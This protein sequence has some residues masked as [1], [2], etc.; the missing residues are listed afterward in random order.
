MGYGG[1]TI[2]NAHF[3]VEWHL[4]GGQS[5][6]SPVQSR[7]SRYTVHTIFTGALS[8]GAKGVPNGGSVKKQCGPNTRPVA[9][10]NALVSYP[11]GCRLSDKTSFDHN[12]IVEASWTFSDYPGYWYFFVRSPV[13]HSTDKVTYRFGLADSLPGNA[14]LGGWNA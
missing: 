3:L 4:T 5:L 14:A 9:A 13:S 8:N 7:V 1:K 12:Q 2:G 6:E 10:A 11:S